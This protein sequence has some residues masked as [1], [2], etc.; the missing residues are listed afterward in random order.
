MTRWSFCA[1]M[2]R[3][4]SV[5]QYIA[6]R[7]MLPDAY[8]LGFVKAA[9]FD[10]WYRELDGRHDVVL[11]KSHAFLPDFMSDEAAWN[12]TETGGTVVL[13]TSRN[14]Y[15]VAESMKRAHEV[16]GGA[17]QPLSGGALAKEVGVV[18]LQ[19]AAWAGWGDAELNQD[20]ASIVR[21]YYGE[22]MGLYNF[23]I[24][25]GLPAQL[26]PKHGWHPA[27]LM[28]QFAGLKD[29]SG[30]VVVHENHLGRG[31]EGELTDE[32]RDL[33]ALE[34]QLTKKFRRKKR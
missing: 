12:L 15:D 21:G 1:G 20:Y 17:A 9:E 5:W 32:E 22:A 29:R 8:H 7:Q 3:S 4:C 30:S 25:A 10:G 18:A 34:L 26:P 23:L 24:L 11:V 13:R 2:R 6:A 33:I 14:S 16:F 19:H 27:A 28:M 31:V